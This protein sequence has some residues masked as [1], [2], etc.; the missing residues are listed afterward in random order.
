[1]ETSK[2]STLTDANAHSFLPEHLTELTRHILLQGLNFQ[3]GP[4]DKLSFLNRT[5][6]VDMRQKLNN[7]YT[8]C[9]L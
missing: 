9:L 8:A 2:K 1:M 5:K 6:A 7:C 3:D 4:R